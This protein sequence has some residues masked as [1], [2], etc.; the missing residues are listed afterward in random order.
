M[1]TQARPDFNPRNPWA[2][3]AH[4]LGLL[5]AGQP[6]EAAA[7]L[8]QIRYHGDVPAQAFEVYA[9]LVRDAQNRSGRP[10]PV[11]TP[12]HYTRH[13]CTDA[14][15]KVLRRPFRKL[16]ADAAPPP[17][18]PSG[19]ALPDLAGAGN[20]AAFL[21]DVATAFAS[22]DGGLDPPRVRVYLAATAR[23][24]LPALAASLAAQD[25]RA[26]VWLT[27][28][29]AAPVALPDALRTAL[30]VQ[31]V[32]GDVLGAQARAAMAQHLAAQDSD[33][34]IFLSG[35][36]VLDP[37]FLARA[38][39]LA[40]ASDRSVQWIMPAQRLAHP[41]L[42]TGA[43]TALVPPDAPFPYREAQGLNMVV[44]TALLARVG[45]PDTR[46]SGTY[47]AARELGYRMA[48]CGA[49]FTALA[50][51]VLERP[52]DGA[53]AGDGS[54][55]VA[56]CP[57][58][59]DRKKDALFERPRVDIY[60]PVYN[61][62]KYIRR[63]VDSV[64]EQDVRDLAVRIADDGSTDGT[65]A[66]LQEHYGDHPQVFLE[67]GSNGGIGHASNRAIAMGDAPYIGQLDSDDCLKP[68]AVRKLM[69]W[70]DRH[71]ETVCAYGSCER[72]DGQ[73]SYI[74]NEF[75][76]PV[77]SREKMMVTSITH[78]FRM[79]RRS[80]W[81]RTAR[82]RED[83]ANAVDYDL[84]LKLSETGGFHHLDEILYQRRWHG[85]N[86]S[87][88]HEA[89]QTANTHIAQNEALGRLGLAPFWELHIA[90]PA[91]PRQV[92]Y[93][94]RAG[95]RT[96][97]FWPN[98]SQ[99]DPSQHMRYARMRGHVEL[100]TGTIEAACEQLGHAARPGDLTFH[101]HGIMCLLQVGGG[102]D[103]FMARL[104]QFVSGGGRFVWTPHSGGE[105]DLSVVARVPGVATRLAVLAHR[106]HVHSRTEA[107]ALARHAQITLP[108]GKLAVAA[109]GNLIGGVPDFISR[110]QARRQLELGEEDE[111]IFVW[112]TFSQDTQKPVRDQALAACGAVVEGRPAARLVLCGTGQGAG[113]GGLGPALRAR[114]RLVETP[115]DDMQLQVF[116][117]AADVVLCPPVPGAVL[118]A[119]GFGV[120]VV[121]R[122]TG[123]TR[124]LLEGQGV[125]ALY[126]AGQGSG[127]VA[128]ALHTVLEECCAGQRAR[129]RAHAQAHVWPDFTAVIEAAADSGAA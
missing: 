69:G 39:H 115:P 108:E 79:F 109:H 67:T 28:F 100:C 27:V 96:V 56:L 72:V 123:V 36:V 62:A 63:A 9:G 23:T 1:N 116:M 95:V 10:A 44:P 82:F 94:R 92:G 30:S 124:E 41:A 74:K 64:L 34:S 45:L 102:V 46:F 80:A 21:R 104:E 5:R 125:G 97:I 54:L 105:G 91:R 12:F 112:D 103:A 11:N 75:N 43:H 81:V 48:Q 117:R 78:H 31:W 77:F 113:F 87:D 90:D 65:Y 66:L 7:A 89:T 2:R 35:H 22:G 93:R 38:L 128:A 83:I 55:Y 73:G 57:N 71:P 70:L 13:P 17:P 114:V 60:I 16:L 107:A 53:A 129:A 32:S 59:W 76:W 37:G 47:L 118:S 4:V 58:H 126:D 52:D 15:G 84:F 3:A 50:V 85:E 122:A 20:D 111:V 106:I 51:P 25:A 110:L 40:R 86:T 19:M 24:D 14:A 8:E 98:H 42:L 49:Y 61:G 29:G 68:G 33:T 26:R 119:L 101:L 18:Y 127:A 120:P 121:T 88:R 6:V 99:A